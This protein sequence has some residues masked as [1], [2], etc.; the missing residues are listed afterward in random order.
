MPGPGKGITFG[1][2]GEQGDGEDRRGECFQ[3]GKQE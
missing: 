1:W 3:R 2:A